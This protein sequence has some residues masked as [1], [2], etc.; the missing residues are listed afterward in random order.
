MEAQARAHHLA[1][2]D[3]LTELPNRVLFRERLDQA[4]VREAQD[5]SRVAVLCLDLDHFKEVNDTLG[6]GA[7]DLLLKELAERLKACIRPTDTVAR[8]GGDEFA[9]IQVGVNQP[10]EVGALSRK[11]MDVV[12]VPFE[13]DDKELYVG[14][15][16]GV[17]LPEGVDDDP[18]RLLK[19]ADIALYRAKQAG[20]GTTRFFE[21]QMDLEL[22]ARKAL[23]YD[24]RQALLKNELEVFYQPL[25]DV[26]T[27]SVTAVEALLR[28]RHP[29]RG[30]VSPVDFISMAEETGTHRRH[31][32]MGAA[33]RLP[34][35]AGMAEPARRGE[36]F[37]GAV[38]QP[39]D[40]RDGDAGA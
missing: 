6:H 37:A 38:P 26:E 34:A 35:G 28:W 8:L 39:R 1:L 13:I 18:E 25:I 21:P 17:A 12:R 22:Q 30:I 40:R 32:R 33:H 29:T 10:L 4:L 31:R 7:G 14:V 5:N 20:R 9:V 11:I 23:E 16:I 15:S 3:S 19:N 36:P 27:E 2:H 24:L